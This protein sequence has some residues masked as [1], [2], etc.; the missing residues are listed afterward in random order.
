MISLL[1]ETALNEM[2]AYYGDEA[3]HAFTSEEQMILAYVWNG[4]S[5]SNTEL[6]QLLGLNSIEVGKILHQMVDKQL[7]NKE[8]KNRWTTYTLLK[9]DSAGSTCEEKSEEKSEE[10]TDVTDNVT[11]KAEGGQKGGQKSNLTT[12][13][14]TE[15]IRLL[16]KD[17]PK[18]TGKELTAKC[19]I[20]EDGVAYH[21]K[22]LKQLGKI[23]RKNSVRK[24][25]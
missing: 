21:I 6:Q 12:E 1:P 13:T 3:Y 11:D 25:L 19:H 24:E 22:E 16:I 10:K 14:T 8:N 5:I 20:T 17:N 4:D 18:I 9:D 7:L 2:K 15:T 23:K